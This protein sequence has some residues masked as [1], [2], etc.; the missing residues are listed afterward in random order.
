MASTRTAHLACTS[1]AGCTAPEPLRNL[2]TSTSSTSLEKSSARPIPSAS[3]GTDSGYA[4]QT[5]TPNDPEKDNQPRFAIA[6]SFRKHLFKKEIALREYQHLSVSEAAWIRFRDLQ[7]VLFGRPLFEYIAKKHPKLLLKNRGQL[8]DCSFRLVM[9]GETEASATPRIVVQCDKSIVKTV[10]RYFGQPNIKEQYEPPEEDNV[11]PSLQLHVFDKAPVKMSATD[12]IPVWLAYAP[13]TNSDVIAIV[14][15]EDNSGERYATI[16]GAIEVVDELGNVKRWGL[17]V[18]HIFNTELPPR[19]THTMLPNHPD[20]AASNYKQAQMSGDDE[21]SSSDDASSVFD[22][23][24]DGGTEFVLESGTTTAHL[25]SGSVSSIFNSERFTQSLAVTA[26]HGASLSHHSHDWAIV[27]APGVHP[28]PFR[29]PQ[30]DSRL[31]FRENR[32]VTIYSGSAGPRLGSL[33]ARSTF[34]MSGMDGSVIEI[35]TLKLRDRSGTW[36]PFHRI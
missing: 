11:F 24:T 21:E 23:E 12:Q 1:T 26:G 17:T 27:D 33:S 25:P 28:S 9:V 32:Q 22:D 16:G 30:G 29:L 4:T 36:F 35:H 31:R 13:I 7:K 20:I 2:K 6:P 15:V 5:S 10:R 19:K 8:L 34:V 18:G 3:D 14:K